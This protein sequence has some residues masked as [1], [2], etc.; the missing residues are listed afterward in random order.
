MLVLIS[1]ML[2]LPYSVM[3]FLGVPAESAIMMMLDPVSIHTDCLYLSDNFS[4]NRLT[5]SDSPSK[6]SGSFRM[7]LLNRSIS[8]AEVYLI[9]T[10]VLACPRVR[11]KGM[12]AGT[13]GFGLGAPPP[14]GTVPPPHKMAVV[15]VA[16]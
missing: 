10:A 15:L 13:F 8:V 2:S 7:A 9:G 11:A 4:L 12:A 1:S 5:D 6:S 3:R 14:A 16:L